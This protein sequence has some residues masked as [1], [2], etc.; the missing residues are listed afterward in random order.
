MTRV[1][2]LLAVGK[3]VAQ[4]RLANPPHQ[5]GADARL[6]NDMEQASRVAKNLALAAR[7]PRA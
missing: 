7:R 1:Q 4:R 5:R 3:R 6:L 2:K